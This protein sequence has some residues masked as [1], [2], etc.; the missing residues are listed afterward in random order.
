MRNGGN[1]LLPVD[2]AQRSL[3]LSLVLENKWRT[4]R[5]MRTYPLMFLSTMSYRTVEFASHQ[6]E[7]MSDNVMKGFDERRENPFEFK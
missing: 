7:W 5:N 2:S 4:D 6:L 1:V 3:E